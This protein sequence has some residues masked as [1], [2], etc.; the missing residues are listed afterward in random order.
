MSVCLVLNVQSKLFDKKFILNLR[1]NTS[2]TKVQFYK[3]NKNEEIIQKGYIQWY[4]TYPTRASQDVW[5]IRVTITFTSHFYRSKTISIVHIC[6]T[7]PLQISLLLNLY[8][9]MFVS[10]LSI[11]RKAINAE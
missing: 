1:L 4:S 3:N 2:M 6:F 8:K 11:L 7:F 5:I 9:S 10:T